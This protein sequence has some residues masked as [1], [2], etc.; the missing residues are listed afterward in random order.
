M[1]YPDDPFTL[2]IEVSVSTKLCMILTTDLK[3]GQRKGIEY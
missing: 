2:A 1:I 3:P